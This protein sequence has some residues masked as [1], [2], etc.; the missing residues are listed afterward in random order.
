MR[1]YSLGGAQLTVAGAT[2]LNSIGN[3]AATAAAAGTTGGVNLEFIRH[4]VGQNANATSAQQRIEFGSYV[5]GGGFGT[6]TAATPAK[7]K[8]QDPASVIVGSTAVKQGSSGINASS[9]G[10]PTRSAI[11]D[12]VFNVLNGYLKVNTPAETEILVQGTASLGAYLW[13]PTAP[14]T[15]TS[16][17]WGQNFR[18][19]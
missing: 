14:A 7:L 12:D 1:E 9:E 16:W 4:W 3:V 13:F 18:E 10:T 6:F 15:L 11:W 8:L 17:T 19:V 2:T 5:V